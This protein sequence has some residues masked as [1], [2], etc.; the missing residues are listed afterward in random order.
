M[1]PLSRQKSLELQR[2]LFLVEYESAEDESHP[3]RV[4]VSV[5]PGT[6]GIRF[7]LPPDVDEPVLWSPGACLVVE[8][9][10]GGRLRIAVEPSEPNGSVA[11]QIQLAALSNDPAG[12]QAVQDLDLSG[13][14]LLGHVA[15]IGDVFA[16]PE[17]WIAGPMALSR[18]E[19]IAL[20]WPEMPRDFGP[21]YAVKISAG[22]R[23]PPP[24]PSPPAPMRAPAGAPCR[25]S[26]PRWKSPAP[27]PVAISS[28]STL[29]FSA[30]RRCG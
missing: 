14:R 24:S 13:F 10:R 28:W 4:M 22:S 1:E 9:E 20:Q 3:P 15:G 26:A 19:G 6:S 27:A 25:W 8:A 18:I 7:V 17:Q 30:R 2:G 5:E 12:A 11:A 21:R 29:F 23:P 16:D